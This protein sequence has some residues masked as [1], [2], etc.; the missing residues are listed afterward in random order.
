MFERAFAK[1]GKRP[2]AKE[3]CNHLT[4]LM[5]IL[6]ACKKDEN[7]VYFTNKGCGLCAVEA[8]F[9]LKLSAVEKEKKGEPKIRG[10][11][12]GNL[13]SEKTQIFKDMKKRAFSRLNKLSALFAF[14]HFVLWTLIPIYAFKYKDILSSKG[15]FIQILAGVLI[16][17]GTF[18]LLSVLQK[19]LPLLQNTV[20]FN[21]LKIYAL[22]N[23]VFCLFAI[24]G[25]GILLIK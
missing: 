17:K 19:K 8:K 3:W 24:N 10:F 21:M 25:F 4:Y 7:H 18:W 6:K 12:V 22:I 13:T 23:A 11:E 5:S 20:L 1:N 9:K 16:L 2:T 14:A 15:F